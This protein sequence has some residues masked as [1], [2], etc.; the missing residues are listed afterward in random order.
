MV[1]RSRERRESEPPIARQPAAPRKLPQQERSRVLVACVR[2]ACLRILDE[3]GARA[4]TTNRIAEVAGVG[5]GSIYQYFPNKEAVV[6]EVYEQVARSE[7]S[8]MREWGERLDRL[9]LEAAIRLMI[10]KALERENRLLKLDREFYRRYHRNFD[11][12][13]RWGQDAHDPGVA[14]D[15]LTRLLER[16]RHK[17]RV[18]DLRLAA[19]LVARG[20]RAVIWLALEERP[21]YI[22]N[23]AFTDELVD[24]SLGYLLTD[25]I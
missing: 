11:L 6:A 7:L 2:E 15:V 22:S 20:M 24:L 9:S 12:S 21:E 1:D 25:R 5:I 18:T 17:L 23:P 19:F 8:S 16:E 3:E 13:T 4:L 10:E 14:V